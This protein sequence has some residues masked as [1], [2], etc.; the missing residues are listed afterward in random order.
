MNGQ[1]IVKT[2]GLFFKAQNLNFL[3][4]IFEPIFFWFGLTRAAISGSAWPGPND[5]QLDPTTMLFTN[6]FNFIGHEMEL[7]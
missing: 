7:I 1:L 4:F 6:Y 3:T 5:F 2:M